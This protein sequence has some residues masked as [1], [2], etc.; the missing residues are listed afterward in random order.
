MPVGQNRADSWLPYMEV[1]APV[2]KM[3]TEWYDEVKDFSKTMVDP[4]VFGEKTGHYSQ[5]VWATSKEVGCGYIQYP[6]S[7]KGKPMNQLVRAIMCLR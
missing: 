2:A 7:Y 5:L 3:V 6:S 4:F 1:P